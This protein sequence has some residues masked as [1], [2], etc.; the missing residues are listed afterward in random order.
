MNNDLEFICGGHQVVMPGFAF[1]FGLEPPVLHFR[2]FGTGLL[3]GIRKQRRNAHSRSAF[4]VFVP[5]PGSA[6]N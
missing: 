3:S 2:L 6:F 4:D 1:P 5:I